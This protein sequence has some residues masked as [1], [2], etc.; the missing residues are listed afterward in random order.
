MESILANSEQRTAMTERASKLLKEHCRRIYKHTD[1][2]FAV[3]LFAQWLAGIAVAVWISP[4]TWAGA[5]SEIHQ[6]VWLAVLLGG[7]ISLP[8][9]A[10][11]WWKPGEILTRHAVAFAQACTSALLIHLSGGRIETHFHIFGSLAFLAF[12]RDWKVLVTASLVIT[13]DHLVRGIY[14]PQS[15]FGNLATDHW[16]WMEHVGWVVFEDIFLAY[17]CLRGQAELREIALRQAELET[18][19]DAIEDIVEQR[20]SELAA[21]NQELEQ[22][23]QYREQIEVELVSARDAAE[24]ASLAKSEFLANM[25]HEIRTPMN[26]VLGMT[27]LLLETPLDEQQRSFAETIRLSGDSLLTII[28]E[29]LDFSKIEAG[30]IELEATPVTLLSCVEEAIDLFGRQAAEKGID[31]VSLIDDNAP[32]CFI[33]D[34]TRVR[35]VLVNLIGNAMKF[36]AT[37]EVFVEVTS[38]RIPPPPDASERVAGSSLISMVGESPWHEIQFKIRDSGVGIPADRMDR[39][40]KLFSQVDASMTR[41]YG[42]TGLG[43]AISKQLTELMGGTIGVES[44]EGKGSTFFFSIVVPETDLPAEE[45]QPVIDPSSFEGRQ[46]LVVDDNATNRRILCIQGQRWGMVTHEAESGEEALEF[47]KTHTKPDV[48]IL[49]MQMPGMDG[50]ELAEKIRA[51]PQLMQLPLIMLSSASMLVSSEDPR[52]KAFVSW[53]N[54]PVRKALLCQALARALKPTP[55]GGPLAFKPVSSFSE[56]PSTLAAEFPLRILLAEDNPVNQKVA[57]LILAKMG[58]EAD[59]VAD[60]LEVLDAIQRRKY[61]LILMDVQMP[62]MDGLETARRVRAEHPEA[63]HLQIIALTAHA[64]ESDHKA[65][66]QAGMDDYLPKPLRPQQLE[67]KLRA[68][69]VRVLQ[70]EG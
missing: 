19:R 15:V 6:H 1:H 50:L 67:Q 63:T 11:V 24:A 31:L 27:S 17:S 12:Y 2:L 59:V 7:A 34:V 18:T 48:A 37:G 49:D 35:Q 54:K 5:S 47:L 61:D 8:P 9:I 45:M 30:H 58:Y 16:R 28:N 14:W 41:R 42:G 25:S 38:T 69:G 22:Q 51:I 56:M 40:F 36:T 64:R 26:G 60:G 20:T 57:K 70:G 32:A 65:C 66:L 33:G 44:E 39:L 52:R 53:F 10:L 23:I 68:A 55:A 21:S 29:I 4:R 3:L 62:N 46:L 43:L 13:V